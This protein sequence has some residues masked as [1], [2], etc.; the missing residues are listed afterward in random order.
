MLRLI[1][2]K[3]F[4]LTEVE[5]ATHRLKSGKA[6]GEDEIQPEMFDGIERGRSTLVDK[7]ITSG[8]GTWKSAK[9]LAERNDHFHKRNQSWKMASVILIQVAAP[10]TKLSL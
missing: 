9:R 2:G 4:T 3:G 7:G 1:L 5:A 6:A 8:V 10:R